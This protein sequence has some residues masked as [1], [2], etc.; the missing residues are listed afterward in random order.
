MVY[1]SLDFYKKQ[2]LN[3]HYFPLKGYFGFHD[4]DPN[5]YEEIGPFKEAF[6]QSL[7][8]NRVIVSNTYDSLRP[9]VFLSDPKLLK[10]F[11]SKELDCTSRPEFVKECLTGFFLKNDQASL[12]Q[13]AV[14][15]AF[16]D[17]KNLSK[18][19]PLVFD[20]FK[21]HFNKLASTHWNLEELKK[22]N[23][24]PE[25]KSIKYDS[26]GPVIFCDIVD[27]I[28]NG[29][30]KPSYT[31]DGK[32]R[33]VHVINEYMV[34]VFAALK[35]PANFFSYKFLLDYKMEPNIWK[36]NKTKTRIVD[37]CMKLINERRET[38]PKS[39]I[40]IID[41]LIKYQDSLPEGEKMSGFD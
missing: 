19:T 6:N 23:E 32:E 40:N 15:K 3:T 4:L 25:W 18:I 27:L 7:S 20:I 13:R 24:E 8:K 37:S 39:T 12:D 1:K 28:L 9:I 10:E 41:S 17:F 5:S 36:V 11:Y 33:L 29:E 34:E 21:K 30:D 16:L 31:S 22:N 26:F 35:S 2:G 14:F 38:G